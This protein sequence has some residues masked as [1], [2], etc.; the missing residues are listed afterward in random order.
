M[1]LGNPIDP[2]FIIGTMRDVAFG[3][4]TPSVHLLVVNVGPLLR[5]HFHGIFARHPENASRSSAT[6]G[7]LLRVEGNNVEMWVPLIIPCLVVNGQ[8]ISG[9][10]FGQRFGEGLRQF[11][12]LFWRCLHRKRY[13]EPLTDSPAPPLRFTFCGLRLSCV[14]RMVQPLPDHL[15]GG[16][17]AGDVSQVCG[18]LSLRGDTVHLLAFWRKCFHRMSKRKECHTLPFWRGDKMTILSVVRLQKLDI[19]NW[20]DG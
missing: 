18:G 14:G 9:F 13:D 19:G 4:E 1:N 8:D 16:R 5:H 17:R 2:L 3:S 7:F 11:Q 12:P 6:P 20:A 15:S 10:S